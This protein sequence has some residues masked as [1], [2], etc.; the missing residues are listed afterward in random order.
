MVDSLKRR[1][2]ALSNRNIST[3]GYHFPWEAEKIE[4]FRRLLLRYVGRIF[5]RV[6][7]RWKDKKK[8]DR[9]PIQRQRVPLSG[10]F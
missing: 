9:S 1:E 2:S 6:K 10:Y 3:S 8:S 5:R 7:K 4:T